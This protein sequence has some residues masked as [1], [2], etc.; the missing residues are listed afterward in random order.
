MSSDGEDIYT[1]MSLFVVRYSK[2]SG[3]ITAP[4]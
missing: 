1:S 2:S 4:V 3:L